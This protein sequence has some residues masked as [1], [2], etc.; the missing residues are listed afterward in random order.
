MTIAMRDMHFDIKG[1]DRTQQAF[2]SATRRARSFN[3][4][5]GM[6]GRA[7]GAMAAQAKALAA[8]IAAIGFIGVAREMREV[9]A[10]ASEL[11]KAADKVGVATDELQR[12]QFGFGQA[13]VAVQDLER[14]L[15][16]WSKRVSEAAF[17]GG[18]LADILQANNVPL[19]DVNGNL[20]SSTDL[21][22]DFAELVRN[23][24]SAQE[25]MTLATE[26]FGRSGGDMILAL[27]D[28]AAG[29]DEL[30]SR[31]DNAGG[32]IREDLLRAAEDLDD[33]FDKLS[34]T[35]KVEVKTA[36]LEFAVAGVDAFDQV[37]AAMDNW[38]ILSK[39]REL[40]ALQSQLQDAR[41]LGSFI[42]SL[43]GNGFPV[44]EKT[45]RMG[46]PVDPDRFNTEFAGL[47][48]VIPETETRKGSARSARAQRD[49][50]AQVTEALRQEIETIGLSQTEQ[51]VL[52]EIRRAG[53]ETTGEQA[54]AIRALV[55]QIE[56]ETQR[57]DELKAQ[58]EA[59][60]DAV[61]SM[62]EMGFEAFDRLTF[63]AGKAK[64]EMRSLAI[65]I[66]RAA[67]EAAFLGTGPLAGFFGGGGGGLFS[68]IGRALFGRAGGGGVDPYGAYVIG[69]DGPEILRMGSRSGSIITNDQAFG[70]GGQGAAPVPV[71]LRIEGVFVDDNG[72]VKGMIT[73]QSQQARTGAVSD[74]KGNFTTWSRQAQVHGR[75]A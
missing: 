30:M 71:D 6:G 31:A 47:E 63:G 33:R 36:L 13:G 69:E 43:P 10:E 54:D 44:K 74:V 37:A 4:E 14:N 67:A 12:M 26:A 34:R 40:S 58:T 19:R 59:F 68:S 60:N 45:S 29:M 46:A 24:G 51:R 16:Q 7:M 52:R 66:A 62:G 3:R 64:E 42:G 50:Y 28:G 1:R 23:A 8:S 21:L 20:R 56:T 61:V 70:G 11:A 32:V 75:P 15:E 72:V 39:I 5:V 49:A 73:K 57:V 65:Q 9:V 41:E 55:L 25:Q 18:R 53:V 35:I 38:D 48:T 22:R 17:F 27:R 2:D